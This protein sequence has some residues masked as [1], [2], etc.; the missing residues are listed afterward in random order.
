MQSEQNHFTFLSLYKTC[1]T[2]NNRLYRFLSALCIFHTPVYDQCTYF[3][4]AQAKIRRLPQ[5]SLHFFPHLTDQFV[6]LDEAAKL[7]TRNQ[8]APLSQDQLRGEDHAADEG[9]W[10]SPHA[11]YR[12]LKALQTRSICLFDA[13]V[14][15]SER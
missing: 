5:T 2:C 10:T 15:S 3:A 14:S 1:S 4:G 7:P 8:L 12:A 11:N 13:G 9:I 6:L